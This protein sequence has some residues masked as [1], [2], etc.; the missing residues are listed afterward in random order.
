MFIV[1][2]SKGLT[3]M[4]VILQPGPDHDSFLIYSLKHHK[5]NEYDTRKMSQASRTR[6][7]L[8]IDSGWEIGPS[9]WMIGKLAPIYQRLK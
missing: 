3:A 1:K 2:F 5:L 7:W 9:T 8:L 4:I 6:L